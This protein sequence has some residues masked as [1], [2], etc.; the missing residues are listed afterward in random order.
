MASTPSNRLKLTPSNS[1]FLGR[2]S[3]S[4]IRARS[5]HES[6]RLS[7]QRVVGTTCSSPTGFDTT[8][9][10]FAY[11]AGGAVIVVD[12]DGETFSQRFYRARPTAVPV[13]A[14]SPVPHAPA[15]PNS[16]P[17]AND[18]RNRV[19]PNHRE[20]LYGLPDWASESPSV[21]CTWTQ[22]ERIKTATCLSLSR[23][24]KFLA[25]GETGYAP[26][27]LIF[28]LQDHSSDIPLVSISE[29][30]FGVT[31]V[32]WS[33][34]ARYLA[35]LGTATDGCLYL[36]KVDPRT[37]AAK[38]FQQNRCNSNV[39]GMIWMGGNLV[40]FGV[41]HVK[42]WRVEE[43]Q[44]ISPVKQK[45]GGDGSVSS[46]QPQKTLPGRNALLGSLLEAAF[47]CGVDL[48]D[49]RAILCSE[50][51]EICLLED[52]GK[53]TKLTKLRDARFPI[54]CVSMRD[55]RIYVGGRADQFASADLDELLDG[56]R[57]PLVDRSQAPRGLLA[58]G[59]LANNIVTID[60]KKTIDV[61]DAQ[62]VTG[63]DGCPTGTHI[64]LPGHGDSIMGIQ[65]L[66][67]PNKADAAFFTWS[68]SGKV[69][70]WS[71]DGKIKSSCEVPVEQ[72][73][74]ENELD[75][76]NQLSIVR[77][78]KGG[79]LFI[80]ADRLGILRVVDFDTKTCRT[81]TKAH[82]SDCQYISLYEEGPTC[83]MASCG[84]DRTA[85]L[86]YR[87]PDGTFEHFQTLEFAAKVVQVLVPSDDKVITCSFDRTL[88][89]HDLV[90][91]EEEPDVMAAIPARVISLRASPSS[92]VMAPDGK[93]IFVSTLDRS[94]TQYEI[95]TGQLLNSFK[96]TDEGGVESA[97][98]DS[99]VFGQPSVDE[100]S[101]L[102]GV[103]NTDKSVRVYDSQSGAFLG[104]EWGHTEAIGGVALID[105]SED[106][107]RR[108]VSVGCDGTVGVW[109]MELRDPVAGT[110]S[111][112]PSPERGRSLASNRPPLRR[113]LSKAELA[114]FQR[115]SSSV[116]RKSPPRT[117][118]RK[119]SKYGLSFM[120][121]ART[122]LPAMVQTTSSPTSTI[123]E[124]TPPSRRASSGGSRSGRPAP[125]SPKSRVTRRPS[126]PAMR[127]TPPANSGGTA[128]KKSSTS[129][130]RGGYGFGSLSMA[131]EQTCRQLRAY[132]KKLA[133]AD[134][135]SQNVLAELDQELRLTTAALGDRVS[136]S[137][138]MSEELNGLLDEKLEKLVSLLDEKWRIKQKRR[139]DRGSRDGGSTSPDDETERL[140]TA[141]EGSVSVPGS[142]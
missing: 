38:L 17:K 118:S 8:H 26:R 4:P 87:S 76:V 32:A 73:P 44:A 83:I 142:A 94:I 46:P 81:E 13:F 66:P 18:S 14:I 19:A 126:L 48:G 6:S 85:Q 90:S 15:T 12:V 122:P 57:D 93:S 58:M 117:L 115:P 39:K 100:P 109:S 37:G 50:A 96:C 69:I 103:S 98:I 54:H 36:W 133:S 59:F 108:V 43:G 52:R 127:T 105:A 107:E 68:G 128:R 33:P 34:D 21:G 106:A 28:N 61:W 75:P 84:R 138:A 10:S 112:D 131:T 129:N 123:A 82:S 29:H 104:R 137:K 132:R 1:P 24:E 67:R 141:S 47:R 63:T 49:G 60:S 9:S 56:S 62:H 65:S 42:V 40:T 51:G 41:R 101:F 16:T 130:L 5:F 78:T 70:L 89:I 91:K 99:L 121:P 2:P 22:R 136:R 30:T 53:Q 31:A 77:A 116:G 125:V 110:M 11:V 134:P 72:A 23:D 64:P 35:S 113:V 74:T 45:F 86:F 55:R 120:A 80:T 88:Q 139:G 25:V 111:R 71:I 119:S 97:V 27:V 140:R 20:S 135:I 3:R 114:E 124:G 92:M 7:L 95:A 79:E 102:L